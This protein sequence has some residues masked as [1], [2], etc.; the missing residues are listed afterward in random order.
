MTRV[1]ITGA[2]CITPIGQDVASFAENLFA[3]HT[4]IREMQD[5]PADLHFTRAAT[6]EDF[7]QQDWLNA[8]QRQ[9]AE[10]S[11]SFAIAARHATWSCRPDCS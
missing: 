10:R 8:N 7:R 5:R 6:V 2:G 1:V 11:S 4:G 9:I 3:G